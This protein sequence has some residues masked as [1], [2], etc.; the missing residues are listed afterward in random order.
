M[1]RLLLTTFVLMAALAAHTQDYHHYWI[2]WTAQGKPYA[3][4]MAVN[5]RLPTQVLRL[6]FYDEQIG[7]YRLIE[8]KFSLQYDYE[9]EA[10][11]LR[12]NRLTDRTYCEA[13]PAYTYSPDEFYLLENGYEL[14]MWCIDAQGVTATVESE[15]ISLKEIDL[16]KPYFWP[17]VSRICNTNYWHQLVHQ[18]FSN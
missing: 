5:T 16:Y 4:V 18:L 1:L 12:N 10:F 7:G 2:T 11:Y 6:T 9:I 3:G 8:Q 17:E 14:Q 13:T 15:F